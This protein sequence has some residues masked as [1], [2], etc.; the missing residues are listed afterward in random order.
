[1]SRGQ[2]LETEM[3]VM[4]ILGAELV[5]RVREHLPVDGLCPMCRQPDPC[6]DLGQ[7]RAALRDLATNDVDLSD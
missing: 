5:S 2:E 4:Q 6:L 3:G 1:M 7:F